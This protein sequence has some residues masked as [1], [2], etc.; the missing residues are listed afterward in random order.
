MKTDLATSILAAIIGVVAAY[1]LCNL[2]L[3]GIDRVTF[4]TLGES[5]T[6]KLVEPNVELFNYRA[7]NP[8]V[9]VY[10]GKC[11]SYNENGECIDDMANVNNPDEAP[12]AEGE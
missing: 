2:I 5:F 8:T 6:Y 7:L 3:P 9:E 1:F 4:K 10:V 12:E 11:Q